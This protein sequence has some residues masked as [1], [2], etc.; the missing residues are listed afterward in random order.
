M[1]SVLSREL[2]ETLITG[3]TVAFEDLEDGHCVSRAPPLAARVILSCCSYSPMDLKQLQMKLGIPENGGKVL[4]KSQ[5][6]QRLSKVHFN[7][8]AFGV[9]RYDSWTSFD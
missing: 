1:L 3:T 8:S 4:R 7:S 2:L 5:E 6:L 9:V